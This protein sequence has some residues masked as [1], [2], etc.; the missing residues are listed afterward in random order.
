MSG[1]FVNKDDKFDIIINYI[2]DKK[3]IKILEKKEDNCKS[4]TMIF[5]YPDFVTA[6]EIRKSSVLFTENG[7]TIDIFKLRANMIYFLL[8]SWDAKD[9]DGKDIK[10]SIENINKLQPVV[11]AYLVNQIQSKIGETD[12]LLM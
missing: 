10:F 12:I 7:Q 11:I 4:L 6:Q 3:E 9:K 5:R 1:I 2:E 8:I